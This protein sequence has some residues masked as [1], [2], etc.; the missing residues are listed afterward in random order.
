MNDVISR[1]ASVLCCLLI[2][3][4][5]VAVPVAAGPGVL[6]SGD[7]SGIAALGGQ[8]EAPSQDGG[9]ET[10]TVSPDLQRTD[11]NTQFFVEMTGPSR[12]DLRRSSQPLETMQTHARKTSKPVRKVI[13]ADDNLE[14]VSSFPVGTMLLVRG[15]ADSTTL[16]RLAETEN[17]ERLFSNFE[18]QS[19]EPM[20]G[21]EALEPAND[22]TTYGLE[23]IDTVEAWNQFDSRGEGAKVAVLDTGVD[24]DHPDIDLYTENESDLTY[25]GG[26]AEFNAMGVQ[27]NSTPRDDASH[28]THTS[29]TVA[30][31]AASSQAIGVAPNVDLMHGMVL[32]DNGGTFAAVLAGIN[33]A[34]EEDA[35]VISMSLGADGFLPTIIEPIRDARAAGTFVVVSSGNSYE[36]TTGSPGNDY[37]SLAVGASDSRQDIAVFSS[38]DVI[39]TSE[40]WGADAPEDWPDTYVVPD[41]SAPGVGVKSATPGGEYQRKAG[42][43]MAA[44]HVAGVVGLIRSVAPN[45]TMSEI[46]TAL[47]TTA[48]KPERAPFEKDVRYGA[49]IVDAD[50]AISAVVDD[51]SVEGTVTSEGDPLPSATVE[52]E[53]GPRVRTDQNG[54]FSIPAEPGTNDLTVS[55]FGVE[56]VTRTVTVDEDGATPVDITAEP[57]VNFRVVEPQNDA[58]TDGDTTSLTLAVA[59]AEELTVD[60][61][62]NYSSENATLRVAGREASFG[63]PVSLGGPAGIVPI[64][65]QT[66]A[67]ATG[68]FSLEHSIAGSGDTLTVTTGP[69]TVADELVDVAFV[70]T[71]GTQNDGFVSDME[72]ALPPEYNVETVTAGNVT[73]AIGQYDTFLVQKF[74][75]EET[76][77]EF[78]ET[79]D[80]YGIGVVLLD[81]RVFQAP[82][83]GSSAITQ[84]SDATGWPDTVENEL[85]GSRPI[86]YD[87]AAEHPI[88]DSVGEPGETVTVH[89]GWYPG[90]NWVEGIDDETVLANVGNA[91]STDGPGLVVD[92]ENN[93]VLAASLG[94]VKNIP[95]DEY[96]PEANALL[97]NA[98]D[99]V[100]SQTD[101]AAV[102][103]MTLEDATVPKRGTAT[104]TLATTAESVA[105]Y[106]ANV[107]FDPD[108][109]QVAAVDGADLSA[110]QVNVDNEAGYV[111]FAQADSS[112]VDEPDLAEITFK[113]VG[114][115]NTA[116]TLDL[117][118]EDS[119]VNDRNGSTVP[120]T[121]KDGT[122]F[123][124][125]CVAGDVNE[126]GV[127]TSG[128]ATLALRFIVGD[129]IEGIFNHV[130]ADVN[131]DGTITSGDVT[132][133]LQRVVGLA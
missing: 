58:V 80:A 120:T 115:G 71:A 131:G 46:E 72:A 74:D 5:I 124:A 70:D 123:T 108:E 35:D 133:I 111:S 56:T 92:E 12:A 51:G 4:S 29:G 62:G 98:V 22:S 16:D 109:V 78:M 53:D 75:D 117:Q 64:T 25:P 118:R 73:A 40:D 122:V 34:V 81:Q 31:G 28:G 104:V 9:N 15:P 116:T 52:L 107:S 45:A 54:S 21:S 85:S 42:T 55:M 126:D 10:A 84:V 13:Q 97:A 89:H 59:N 7:A 66:T 94:R 90:R 128:D 61:S 27:L 49:G 6:A 33:W 14:L 50:A 82:E 103:A 101:S 17:V 23:Q 32:G 113:S 60:I 132:G 125:P 30:G 41:V 130:C 83:K 110:P 121:F 77:G 67:G 88:V 100:A 38:G 18:V 11:G 37:G 112:A 96:S 39:N 2:V 114:Q 79:T 127:V 76:A 93:T 47:T 48:T 68:S 87:L 129:D 63:K 95:N 20:T 102:P 3:L 99:H 43:S 119:L 65:V 26:W 24:A 105:G 57:T 44:P 69:T 8:S 19:P 86:T 91:E 106:Q 36:G 1:G